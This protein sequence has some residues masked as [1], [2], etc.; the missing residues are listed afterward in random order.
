MSC[1]NSYCCPLC[2]TWNELTLNI[3][4]REEGIPYENRRII[5]ILSQTIREYSTHSHGLNGNAIRCA[6]ITPVIQ[7]VAARKLWTRASLA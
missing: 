7:L 2:T 6:A 1:L 5:P 3:T 4:S